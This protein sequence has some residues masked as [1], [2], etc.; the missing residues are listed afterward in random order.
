MSRA[1]NHSMRPPRATFPQPIPGVVTVA[2]G[3]KEPGKGAAPAATKDEQPS[4][5]TSAVHTDRTP[6][7]DT[8]TTCW[9]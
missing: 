3:D 6:G 4:A 2:D 5:A 8:P 7:T 9:T 1:D